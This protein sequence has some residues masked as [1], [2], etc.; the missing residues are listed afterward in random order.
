MSELSTQEKQ[1]PRHV[2]RSLTEREQKL[3]KWAQDKLNR[4]RQEIKNAG[5]ERDRV[6][7]AHAVLENRNWFTVPGPRSEDSTITL[8]A[9]FTNQPTAICSIRKGDILMVGRAIPK[10]DNDEAKIK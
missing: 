1:Q 8:W 2:Q 7:A 6:R 3:P 4:L 5:D 9:L 10:E